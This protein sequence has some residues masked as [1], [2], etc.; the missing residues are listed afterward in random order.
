MTYDVVVI[1]GGVGGLT[2]AALLSARGWNTCLIERQSQVG[3]CI[4]RV[5]HSGY[6]FEPGMGLYNGWGPGEIYDRI[7]SELPIAPPAT[8]SLESDYKVRLAHDTDITLF[9]S[10]SEFF[11]ELSRAFPEGDDEAIEFYKTVR[12]FSQITSKQTPDRPRR[13][14]LRTLLGTASKRSAASVTQALSTTALSYA[15][16]TSTRF[17]RFIDAQLKA[18]LHTSIDRCSFASACTALDSPRQKLYSL[19]NGIAELADS[20]AASIKATGGTV[21]LNAPVLRLAY[22][23]GGEV[24]GVDLL[25]GETVIA[26]RAVV[27]NLTVWDTYGRLFGLKRTPA[28]IKN[29]LQRKQSSGAYV[30]YATIEDQTV[31]KLPA[32]NFI[33]AEPERE[34]STEF[35]VSL[36]NDSLEGKQ[37]ATVKTSTEVIPW[38]SFQTSEEDYEQRDQEALEEFWTKLHNAVPELG[39][40]IEVIETANPRTYYDETRRK[41]GMVLGFEATPDARSLQTSFL[42]ALPNVFMVGDT[43]AHHPNLV[44]VV[45]SAMKLA[46]HLSK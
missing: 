21:R 22:S 26:T 40:G 13:G 20:L 8:S 19:D 23:P 32:R 12:E 43:T 34:N 9:K 39:S 44:S 31:A 24:A 15:T 27:S 29:E 18:L 6:E 10:D 42:T 11:A 2:V 14:I 33:V 5:E 7:F 4:A 25:S 45:D 1:G 37:S 46:D 3:G 28:E 38:F 35:S 36:T 16:N 30:I 17:Q 41:L